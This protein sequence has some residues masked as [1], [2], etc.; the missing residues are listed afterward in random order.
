MWVEPPSHSLKDFYSTRYETD[1][2]KDFKQTNGLIPPLFEANFL[3]T[4]E[5]VKRKQIHGGT[6][7]IL[8]FRNPLV[9]HPLKY[10]CILA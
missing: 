1:Y 5:Q 2:H 10:L 4:A 3:G 7:N 9:P 8:P 6:K